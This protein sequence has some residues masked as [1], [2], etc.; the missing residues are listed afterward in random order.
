MASGDKK[1]LKPQRGWMQAVR[2]KDLVG[3]GEGSFPIITVA[4][5]KEGG[6][7]YVVFNLV[8][9]ETPEA[10]EAWGYLCQAVAIT[11]GE[12][13]FHFADASGIVGE[14]IEESPHVPMSI[15]DSTRVYVVS[16]DT[17][18]ALHVDL[19]DID[20]ALRKSKTWTRLITENKEN[21][22]DTRFAVVKEATLK[23]V[24]SGEPV[25]DGTALKFFQEAIA[26]AKD[27]AEAKTT[28]GDPAPQCN[29]GDRQTNLN[30]MQ[31]AIGHLRG[32]PVGGSGDGGDVGQSGFQK[33][34]TTELSELKTLVNALLVERATTGRSEPTKTAGGMTSMEGDGECCYQAAGTGLAIVGGI[35]PQEATKNKA[36]RVKDAKLKI[37]ENIFEITKDLEGFCV[38]NDAGHRAKESADIWKEVIGMTPEQVLDNVLAEKKWAATSSSLLLFGVLI[39]NQS[40]CTPKASMPRP[41][42]VRLR[43]VSTKRC[44]LGSRPAPPRPDRFS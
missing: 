2:D 16:E 6:Y 18:A 26:L 9:K 42:T 34:V 41:L 3:A 4:A 28:D 36:T 43:P 17:S 35:N 10:S 32:E 40:S 13:D 38:G 5:V 21:K 1:F 20:G 30:Y 12:V 39:P 33:L 29:M 31:S 7:Y 44:L 27:K 14:D 37:V 25:N 19:T 15:T 8:D 22:W 11:D 24:Q 23:L